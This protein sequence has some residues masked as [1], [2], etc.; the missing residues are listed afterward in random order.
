MAHEA[1]QFI[2]IGVSVGKRLGAQCS[3]KLCESGLYIRLQEDETNAKGNAAQQ[4]PAN[5]GKLEHKG[6]PL[7]T[8]HHLLAQLHGAAGGQVGV[9]GHQVADLHVAIRPVNAGNDQK[10]TQ[11]NFQVGQQHNFNNIQI[12]GAEDR[13]DGAERCCRLAAF[14]KIAVAADCQRVDEERCP[15]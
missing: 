12:R 4:V 8:V 2:L 9:F 3:V 5:K 13:S 10:G 1:A 11:R 14:H 15:A 7:F 6:V